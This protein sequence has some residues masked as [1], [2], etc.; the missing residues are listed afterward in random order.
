MWTGPASVYTTTKSLDY[1][2]SDR[3][4]NL[5]PESVAEGSDSRQFNSNCMLLDL[6]S[7]TDPDLCF[8]RKSNN[9]IYLF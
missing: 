4:E 1:N 8:M 3:F 2:K 7:T 5:F 9:M 6:H